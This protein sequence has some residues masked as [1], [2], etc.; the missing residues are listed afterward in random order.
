MNVLTCTSKYALYV[1]GANFPE[2]YDPSETSRDQK[3][4]NEDPHILVA[5]LKKLVTQATWHSGFGHPCFIL[6]FNCSIFIVPPAELVLRAPVFEILRRRKATGK[7]HG[8][9]AC[10]APVIFSV[11]WIMYISP[12]SFHSMY[13]H[14]ARSILGIWADTVWS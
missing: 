1:R 14:Y 6:S 12:A 9:L 8:G 13:C 11:S 3:G 10:V 4:H 7:E 2:T 5:T